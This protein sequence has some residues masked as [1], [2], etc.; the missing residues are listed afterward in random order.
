M[1]KFQIVVEVGETRI[2]SKEFEADTLDDAMDMADEESW[3]GSSASGWDQ[4]DGNTL[5]EIREE[6]CKKITD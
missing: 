6:L 3:E 1:P 4:I 5:A 2:L